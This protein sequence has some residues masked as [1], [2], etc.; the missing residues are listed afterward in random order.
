MLVHPHADRLAE[1]DLRLGCRQ[2][3]FARVVSQWKRSFREAAMSISSFPIQ[4]PLSS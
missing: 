2:F 1:V 3:Q 4:R